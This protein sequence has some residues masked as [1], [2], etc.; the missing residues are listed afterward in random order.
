VTVTVKACSSRRAP[1]IQRSSCRSGRSVMFF[2][3][4]LLLFWPVFAWTT[5]LNRV[6]PAAAGHGPPAQ[7]PYAKIDRNYDTLDQVY[8]ELYFDHYPRSFQIELNHCRLTSP[9]WLG[10]NIHPGEG[11]TS[12][13]WS[14]VLQPHHRSGFHQEQRMDRYEVFLSF[15]IHKC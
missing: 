1:S 3:T 8:D 9:A 11:S 10:E 12:A 4:F 13:G 5:R 15:I 2:S 14:R 7:R 6:V